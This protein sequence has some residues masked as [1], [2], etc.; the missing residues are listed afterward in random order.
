MTIRALVC[1]DVLDDEQP[2]VSASALGLATWCEFDSHPPLLFLN[3]I[4]HPFV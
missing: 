3:K 1:I 2:L 4:P